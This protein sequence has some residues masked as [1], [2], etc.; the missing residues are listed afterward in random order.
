MQDVMGFEVLPKYLKTNSI[1]IAVNPCESDS[2]RQTSREKN[3]NA[4]WQNNWNCE[5]FFVCA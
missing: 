3:Y 5:Q 1:A 2:P 4:T